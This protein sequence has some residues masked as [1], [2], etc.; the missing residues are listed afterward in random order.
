MNINTK[1]LSILIIILFLFLLYFVLSVLGIFDKNTAIAV[2][3]ETNV[4]ELEEN[5]NPVDI[6]T[7]LQENIEENVSKEM[8]SEE[9]DLEYTTTYK[10]NSNLPSGTIQVTQVGI[11]GL[12]ETITVKKYVNDELESEEIVASNI[13]KASIDKVVEIGT[14]IW[15]K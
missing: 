7:I 4:S 11:D 12:Q 5:K 1:K 10:E 6:N 2:S 9:I 8:V 14:R 3:T 15:Y 13:K